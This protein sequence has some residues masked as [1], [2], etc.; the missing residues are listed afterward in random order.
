MD[1]LSQTMQTQSHFLITA[2]AGDQLKKR[3][4]KVHQG[5]FLLGSILPDIPLVLLTFWFLWQQGGLGGPD[6]AGER[7]YDQN[8]FYN[9]VWIAGHNFFHAPFDIAL[10]ALFGYWGVKLNLRWGAPLLWFAA[11]CGFH[12]L[13]DIFTH[14]SDG[15]LPF[16]PFNWNYRFHSPVSYYEANHF[17]RIFMPIELMLNVIIILFFLV[18]W[19][20]RR[21]KLAVARR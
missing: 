14:Y 12:S 13:V 8:Y 9:P 18:R 16:F 11:G 19:W 2:V 5:A 4:V 3:G 1:Q 21:G 20:K 10:F 15:P 17:G 7:L 6:S